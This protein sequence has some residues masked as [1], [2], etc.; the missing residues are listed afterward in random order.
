MPGRRLLIPNR[1]CVVN[2]GKCCYGIGI[3]GKSYRRRCAGLSLP[4]PAPSLRGRSASL[5]T[6]P[7]GAGARLPKHLIGER[8][9]RSDRR[10]PVSNR[11]SSLLSGKRCYRLRLR[12]RECMLSA[13]RSTA[14]NRA[15]IVICDSLRPDL[16]T[17]REAPFLTELGQRSA[18]FA[19]HAGVFPST[20]RTSAA[21]IATGCLPARHGLLGNTMALDEGDGLVCLS[22]GQA[23]FS[24]PAAPRDRP[25]PARADLGRAARPR[26][27]DRDRVLECLTGSGLFSR[28]RRLWLG[29]QRRRQLRP[30]PAAAAGRGRTR[31]RQGGSRGHGRD[32]AVL[33]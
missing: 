32:R 11:F 28:P 9:R 12:P 31:D 27:R 16:I 18:R 20:T 19:N 21:S 33:R 15:V 13:T 14:M 6:F 25:H 2:S 10:F 1:V 22:V 30:R 8:C 23:G 26:R 4:L 17:R 3:E 7:D 29:L 5:R 24:R